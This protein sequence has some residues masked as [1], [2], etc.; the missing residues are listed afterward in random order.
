MSN[1]FLATG[2]TVEEEGPPDPI[3][4]RRWLVKRFDSYRLL[5]E[6][7]EASDVAHDEGEAR[8]LGEKVG[9]PQ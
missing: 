4:G 5:K 9:R 6:I 1:R 2:Y 3:T 8:S 7:L